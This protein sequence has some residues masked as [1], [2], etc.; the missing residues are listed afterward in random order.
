MDS[1]FLNNFIVIHLIDYSDSVSHSVPYEYPGALAW[2][3]K[4][5][6]RAVI[7]KRTSCAWGFALPSMF[8]LELFI[9]SAFLGFACIGHLI[10]A[11]V[12]W[13]VQN[14][15]PHGWSILSPTTL[16]QI[17]HLINWDACLCN[18]VV[19]RPDGTGPSYYRKKCN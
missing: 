12:P 4:V 14:N 17:N 13:P 16:A 15:N 3:N 2:H 11:H 7:A 5:P 9:Q 6:V 19:L 10:D 8:L 18:L 1:S